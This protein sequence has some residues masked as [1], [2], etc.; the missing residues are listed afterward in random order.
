MDADSRFVKTGFHYRSARNLSMI[1]LTFSAFA[2][3][4]SIFFQAIYATLYPVIFGPLIA[5]AVMSAWRFHITGVLREHGIEVSSRLFS[6][7]SYRNLSILV[8]AILAVLPFL[9]PA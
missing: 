7:A 6:R 2:F 9:I 3:Y 1:L 8:I 4:Y 5:S